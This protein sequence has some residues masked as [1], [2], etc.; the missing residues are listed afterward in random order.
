MIAL[1]HFNQLYLFFILARMADK[2]EHR[3]I[4]IPTDYEMNSFV[5]GNWSSSQNTDKCPSDPCKPFDG[6]VRPWFCK[7]PRGVNTN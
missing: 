5:G 1:S 4:T 6:Y 3:V 2:G 7:L